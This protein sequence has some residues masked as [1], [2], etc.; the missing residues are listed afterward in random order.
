LLDVQPYPNLD[1]QALTYI[2]YCHSISLFHT[3]ELGELQGHSL[4]WDPEIF[5]RRHQ[6][7][8]RLWPH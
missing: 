4:T 1:W 8:Y 5:W 7:S 3:L 2:Q 6:S